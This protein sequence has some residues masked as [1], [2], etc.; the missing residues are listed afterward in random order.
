MEPA[1]DSN[2]PSNPVDQLQELLRQAELQ[3]LQ[4]QLELRFKKNMA[5]FKEAAPEIYHQFTSYEP[6][7]LRLLY[8]DDGHLNLVN[9]TLD[10]KP[11]YPGDPKE[12]IATQIKDFIALPS[13]SSVNFAKSK[14]M[15]DAHIHAPLVNHLI[16]SYAPFNDTIKISCDQP[17]GMFLMTGVGLGYQLP[18][19]LEK[20]D[21]YTLCIFDPHKDSFYASLH[22]IDWGEVIKYFLRPHRMIKLLVGME[23][24]DA[25]AELRLLTDRIGL[26]NVVFTFIY[27]H[28]G[29]TKE[30]EFINTYKKE[31]HLNATGTGFF[32]DEQVSFSHTVANL[33]NQT[34][35]FWQQPIKEHPLPPLLLIGN[36]P[37]L[38]KHIEFLQR[39]RNNAIVMSCGTALSS[40]SKRKIKPDFHVEMERNIDVKDWLEVGT[41]PEDREGVTLLCLNTCAPDVIRMFSDACLAKKPNDCGEVIIDDIVR[42][43]CEGVEIRALPLCNPTVT[44][45]GLSYALAMGFTEIYLVGVDLGMS[46]EGDHHSTLSPYHSLAAKT[47]IKDLSP[48][49]NTKTN[50]F[51]KGNFVDQVSTS[52]FLDSTRV[53]MQILLTYYERT[54]GGINVYNSNNGALIKGTIPKPL[55]EITDFTALSD[56]NIIIDSLK[57][58]HFIRPEQSNSIQKTQI[59]HYLHNYFD[60]RKQI[61]LPKKIHDR[62]AFYERIT[63][64]FSLVRKQRDKNSITTML[65]RGS[66]H[67]YFTLMLRACLFQKSQADYERAY[68]IGRKAYMTFLKQCYEIMESTPLKLDDTHD[69]N[70]IAARKILG[71]EK[72]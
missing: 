66:M 48:L 53:N 2:L 21:I 4:L 10:N 42:K 17:I 72:C 20:L 22:T 30:E 35:I 15:N 56:K 52:V 34:P 27:R 54:K 9:Y 25:M 12:F 46:P 38:D 36:G 68:E 40:L 24:Q 18:Q 45:A 60:I 49:E 57:H 44:N 70:I 67:G 26:H 71:E 41:E 16:D 47:Q 33:N 69:K 29:S 19:L 7:E 3:N 11:V 6:K 28:F 43:T 37:S 8:T 55:A 63:E 61:G 5:I 14:I 13:I 50:Y 32:D 58:T 23:T 62:K 1:H 39:N 64:I 51:I 59:K 65:L 31:F